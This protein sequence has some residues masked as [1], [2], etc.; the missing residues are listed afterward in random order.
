MKRFALM[1]GL[2][3]YGDRANINNVNTNDVIT[4]KVKGV[5]LFSVCLG[6][7]PTMIKVVDLIC[8]NTNYGVNLY[9]NNE[10][11]TTTKCLLNPRRRIFKVT[12]VNIININ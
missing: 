5:W 11:N 9:K 12:N 6:T 10:Q 1:N 4:Y 8:E 3:E 2:P 7:T